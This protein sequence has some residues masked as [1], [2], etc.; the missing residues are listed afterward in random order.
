VG[1]A[2]PQADGRCPDPEPKS[3]TDGYQVVQSNDVIKIKATLSSRLNDTSVIGYLLSTACPLASTHI[4][5]HRLRQ[6]TPPTL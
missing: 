3:T 6:I 1:V 4:M 5:E 2:S